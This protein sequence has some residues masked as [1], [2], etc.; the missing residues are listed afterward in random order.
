VKIEDSLDF[1]RKTLALFLVQDMHMIGDEEGDVYSS[2]LFLIHLSAAQCSLLSIC[3]ITLSTVAQRGCI[4]AIKYKI[5]RSTDLSKDLV[6]QSMPATF[7]SC[8]EAAWSLYDDPVD[9]VPVNYT[10]Y[11]CV[12]WWY[13]GTAVGAAQFERL[14]LFNVYTF[15]PAAVKH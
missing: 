4:D 14:G 3:G 1:S 6:Q 7:G 13:L 12:F 9:Y 8:L 2:G 15:N 5:P 11:L 10:T